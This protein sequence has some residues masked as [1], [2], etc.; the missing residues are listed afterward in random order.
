MKSKDLIK[1]IFIFILYSLAV[2]FGKF[3]GA[4]DFASLGFV[5]FFCLQLILLGAYAIF[6]QLF[7]RNVMLSKAYML[8]S[9]TL[10]FALF[11]GA[12]FFDEKITLSKIIGILIIF[13][14]ITLVSRND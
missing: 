10:V 2:L 3:A 1:G 9:I 14:G 8:K 11:F 4:S 5:F 6:W 13:L 12:F 7:L